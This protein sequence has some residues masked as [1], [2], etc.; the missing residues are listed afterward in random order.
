MIIIPRGIL[1][2]KGREELGHV[3]PDENHVPLISTRTVFDTV[4]NIKFYQ[5][6]FSKLN[7]IQKTHCISFSLKIMKRD[8]N[9]D[10]SPKELSDWFESK[11]MIPLREEM[12]SSTFSNMEFYI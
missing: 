4:R 7:A 10:V 11:G 1:S 5:V 6:D 3:F 12:I 9:K 2:E 8:E